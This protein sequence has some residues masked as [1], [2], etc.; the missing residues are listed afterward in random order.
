MPLAD[1][2]ARTFRET[3][4]AENRPEDMTLHVSRA[5]AASQL[6]ADLANPEIATLLVEADGQLAGYAQLRANGAPD[7]VRGDT[8]L[9][10]W[11]FYVAAPWH[12]RGVAHALMRNVEL[13]ARA[14]DADTLW[15]G[16]WER[17]ER[18]QSFYRKC[19]FTDVGSQVFLLG[20]DAQTDRIM[21]RLLP[22]K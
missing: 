18:A 5:F 15:L 19:G 8:P 14:R 4:A 13:E 17:N 16:V 22:G 21:V 9:E 20:T 7:C 10:L 11:R 6:A 1:L 2:A 3:Y 12:G